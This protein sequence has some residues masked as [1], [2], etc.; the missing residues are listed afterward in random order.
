MLCYCSTAYYHLET[1]CGMLQVKPIDRDST[2]AQQVNIC[3]YL[4]VRLTQKVNIQYATANMMLD[5]F[6]VPRP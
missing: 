2:L 6:I 5:I 1:G 3:S 4:L